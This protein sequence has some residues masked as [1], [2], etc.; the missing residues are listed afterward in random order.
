MS[1]EF[2]VSEKIRVSL[3]RG[4]NNHAFVSRSRRPFDGTR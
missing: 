4:A 1:L 2:N 3:P